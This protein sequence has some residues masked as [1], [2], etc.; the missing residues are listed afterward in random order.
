MCALDCVCV[1]VGGGGV[2][3]GNKS[4]IQKLKVRERACKLT[5]SRYRESGKQTDR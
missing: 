1:C 3:W 5:E 2:G 4:S